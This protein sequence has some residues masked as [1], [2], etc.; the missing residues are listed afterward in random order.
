MA[1]EWLGFLDDARAGNVGGTFEFFD[2]EAQIIIIRDTDDALISTYDDVALGQWFDSVWVNNLR[3]G[4]FGLSQ[5]VPRHG[6]NGEIWAV[7]IVPSLVPTAEYPP[8]PAVNPGFYLFR[9]RYYQDLTPYMQKIDT[10]EQSENPIKDAGLTLV[11]LGEGD[12]NKTSSL[13]SPGSRMVCKIGMGE[14]SK[15]YFAT[16]YLDQIDWSAE[17]ESMAITGRNALGYFL[18]D[19]TFDDNR[20]FSGT[21]SSVIEDMLTGT[22]INMAKVII[23]P[24]GTEASSPTF[25]P[26]DTILT[27][28]NYVL[29]VWGWKVKELPNGNIIIGTPAFMEIYAPVTVHSLNKDEAFARGINQSSDGAYSRIALQSNINDVVVNNVVI[30]PAWTRTVFKDI[31]YLDSWSLGSRRTL[32]ISV[33]DDMS[34]A[35]M[36]TLADEYAKAYQYIGINMTRELSIHPEIATG[37]PF[38]IIDLVDGEFMDTGIITNVVHT[39][40]VENGS[41]RT[42]LSVNSGGTVV[43]GSTIQTYTAA[44]V[45]GD[46]R[47]REL[48]DIIKKEAK[49]IADAKKK[50]S[51]SSSYSKSVDGGV[52]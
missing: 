5:F 28:L 48:I 19:Q 35:A 31:N 30:T 37:D 12:I 2:T 42:F 9:Y 23:D 10:N 33:L 8:T 11:N 3:V 27:G 47:R 21:R 4:N 24:A 39:I 25:A 51:A 45:D 36:E 13:F 38:E 22:G 40:D 52:G 34:E 18:S 7:G 14:S 44:N 6:Y 49:R 50:Q 17:A 16:V 41:A 15:V 20:T 46:T 29:D 26:T 1:I 32:Y 43:I